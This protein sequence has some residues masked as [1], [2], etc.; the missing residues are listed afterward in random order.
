MFDEKCR[1]KIIMKSN[2]D[3]LISYYQIKEKLIQKF[4]YLRWMKLIHFLSLNLQRIALI[5]LRSNFKILNKIYMPYTT[6][7]NVLYGD[8]PIYEF[9]INILRS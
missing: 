4:I 7:F 5:K 9:N 6:N 8:L 1:K 2:L 3:S